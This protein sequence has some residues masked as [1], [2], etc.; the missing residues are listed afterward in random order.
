MKTFWSL[1]S[2]QLPEIDKTVVVFF[3]KKFVLGHK[4]V[5]ENDAFST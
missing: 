1:P 5:T 2:L 3:G 4:P